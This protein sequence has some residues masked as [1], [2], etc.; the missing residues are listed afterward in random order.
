MQEFQ[1]QSGQSNDS[2]AKRASE[3]DRLSGLQANELDTVRVVRKLQKISNSV[4]SFLGN[5]M[6]QL[7]AAVQKFQTSDNQLEMLQKAVDDLSSQR[8]NWEDM[9]AREM[10]RL[11]LASEKLAEGWRQL[12]DARRKW[13][14]EKSRPLPKTNSHLPQSQAIHEEQTVDQ[15]CRM[16]GSHSDSIDLYQ[17]EKLRLEIQN[18]SGRH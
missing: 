17:M 2:L 5:Q 9:K 11:N 10:E 16:V 3:T 4:E 8:A 14:M 6:E 15:G 18:H 13:L 7:L 12:E 1:K